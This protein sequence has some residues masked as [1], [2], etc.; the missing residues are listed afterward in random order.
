M[1]CAAGKTLLSGGGVM[2][3]TDTPDKIEITA[4]YPSA[5]TTWTVTGSALMA[6]NKTWTVR[7]YAVCAAD[8][9][10]RLRRRHGVATHHHRRGLPVSREASS[11]VRPP[12]RGRDQL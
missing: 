10:A 6:K 4:S 11:H 9:S 12:Q 3:T 2:T 8:P 7:A 1:S 5:L